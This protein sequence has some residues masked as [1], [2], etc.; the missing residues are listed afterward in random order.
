MLDQGKAKVKDAVDKVADAVTNKNNA[1]QRNGV[2]PRVSTDQAI[3]G[4]RGAKASAPAQSNAPAQPKANYLKTA[5]D[6]KGNRIGF[7]AATSQ[8]EPLR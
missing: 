5:I 2:T 8:W 1:M 4:Y 6:A 7:N 3:A